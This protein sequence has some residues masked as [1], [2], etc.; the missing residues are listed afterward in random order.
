VATSW[1]DLVGYVRVRYEIF[2]QTDRTLR[3]HLPT[4]NDRTQRV[5][6]H[7]VPAEL[8]GSLAEGTDWVVIESAVGRLDQLD[9]RALLELAGRT[10]VGGVVAADG[11]A[12]L[13][14]TISLAELSLGAFD[15]PFRLVADRADA[16]E[17][18][19]TGSDTF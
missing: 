13:R 10:V 8:S 11:V 4:G 2:Q 3:F 9:L 1:T 7:H 15:K 16:L 14:H 19:L 12:L 5:A 6:V 18:E 17:A